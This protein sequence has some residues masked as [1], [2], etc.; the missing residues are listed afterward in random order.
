LTGLLKENIE[1]VVQH[2]K[3]ADSIIKNMLLH[4]REGSGECRSADI[5]ALVEESLN[6]AYHGARA[7]KAGFTITLKQDLDP[8]A[9]SIELY[10]QEVTRAL[11]NLI[12]NGFYAA[13][14]RKVK[15]D[16][17]SLEPFLRATTRVLGKVVEIRIRA[18]PFLETAD[19]PAEGRLR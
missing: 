14:R 16:D 15:A 17:E 5:N 13:T 8:N 19:G 18:E 3:R 6:L 4:S 9:G 11:L 7:E 1:K 12:S 2:G 10:P